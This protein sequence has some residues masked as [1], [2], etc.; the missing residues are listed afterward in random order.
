M[1]ICN[2]NPELEIAMLDKQVMQDFD[3]ELA[4]VKAE[5]KKCAHI[6][7]S[8]GGAGVI[9]TANKLRK[10]NKGDLVL[11][12]PHATAV[13][14]YFNRTKSFVHGINHL[15]KQRFYRDL[16]KAVENLPEGADENQVFE[17]LF[18]ITR[19]IQMIV[20][21]LIEDKENNHPVSPKAK[22][23]KTKGE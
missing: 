16:A 9:V 7:D 13:G 1:D 3:K 22:S 10:G 18:A 20:M 11:I 17:E 12:T 23:S 21:G 4:K 15:T 19:E 8:W 14:W 2:I 6:R 5:I